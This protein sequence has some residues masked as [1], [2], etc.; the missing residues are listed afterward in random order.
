MRIPAL[1]FA[2]LWIGVSSALG[3]AVWIEARIANPAL[4][5]KASERYA[6]AIHGG[7]FWG[8]LEGSG[9]EDAVRAALEQGDRWLD[10]GAPALDVVEEVVAR[11]EDSGVFNAGKGARANAAG[12][13]ELDA[14][15]MDGRGRRVGAVAAVRA[16]KNPVRAARMVMRWT[17][18]VLLSGPSADEVLA[19]HGA[20]HAGPDYFGAMSSTGEERDPDTVG[21]VALDRCGNL[22]AAT[23]TGGFGAKM[24]GRVGDSPIPGAGLYAENGVVAVSAT[25]EGESFLRTALAHE[26]AMRITLAGETLAEATRG[27]IFGSLTG[28]GGEGGVVAIDAEGNFVAAFNSDGMVRGSANWQSPPRTASGAE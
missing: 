16:L 25:G 18:H 19:A 15:I 24:P 13:V 21:A 10:A 2:F 23:S 17:P 9:R 4:R 14:A 27:A 7:A 8:E 5:C 22:A 26:I 3:D 1:V 6:I 28:I 20:E 11:L 12:Y